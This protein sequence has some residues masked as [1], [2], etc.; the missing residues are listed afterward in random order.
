LDSSS[1]HFVITAT[2]TATTTCHHHQQQPQTVPVATPPSTTTNGKLHA[3]LLSECY[4][5]NDDTRGKKAVE[6]KK[7]T[8]LQENQHYA[9]LRSNTYFIK[10]KL[11]T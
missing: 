8:P 4:G 10:R 1:I 9:F 6:Y 7:G 5:I 11:P 2:T 3:H